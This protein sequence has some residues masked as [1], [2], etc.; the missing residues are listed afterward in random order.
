MR[1]YTTV[2]A[3]LTAVSEDGL[4]L[5]DVPEDLKTPEVCLKAVKQ[6]GRAPR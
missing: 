6:D 2:E 1:K 5:R 4:A 3:A